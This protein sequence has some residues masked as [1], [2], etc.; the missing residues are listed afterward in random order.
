MESWNRFAIYAVPPPGPL[1]E[2]TAQWL[3]WDP[4]ASE[5]RAAPDM[6]PLPRPVEEITRAPRKYGFHG[7]L[8]APFRPAPGVDLDAIDQAMRTL[9]AGSPPVTLPLRLDRLG[10]FLALIPDGPAPAL[11]ALAARVVRATDPLR[12]ALTADEYARRKP[13][14]LDPAQR[15]L[16]DRWGYPHVMEGFRYHMTLTGPLPRAELDA[17]HAT[18]APYMAP[19]LAEPFTL[20]DLALCGEA[21]DGRFHLIHRYALSG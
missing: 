18:L 6:G 9:S 14:T 19:H 5:T 3:G 16:L 7:T 8:R 2:I 10:A 12:A 13:E 1:F 4:V 15:D 20:A 17:V 11:D 21:A